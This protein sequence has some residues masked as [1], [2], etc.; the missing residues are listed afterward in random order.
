VIFLTLAW[1][2]LASINY[3]AGG[4]RAPGFSVHIVFIICVGFIFGKQWA[5]LAAAISTSLGAIF[6]FLENQG[7]LP[8]AQVNNTPERY[9]LIYT[10]NFFIIAPF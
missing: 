6:L 8:P 3:T 4:V 7:L 5:F 9:W 10:A 2:A 1:V